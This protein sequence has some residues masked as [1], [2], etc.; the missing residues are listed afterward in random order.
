MGIWRCHAPAPELHQGFEMT[1]PG[2]AMVT[3]AADFLICGIGFFS[4]LQFC[5]SLRRQIRFSLP[6]PILLL[7]L[8]GWKRKREAKRGEQCDAGLEEKGLMH[9]QGRG[10]H[11]SHHRKSPERWPDSVPGTAL[12]WL[13][14]WMVHPLLLNVAHPLGGSHQRGEMSLLC[15]PRSCK[16]PGDCSSFYYEAFLE[17]HWVLKSSQR[18][19]FLWQ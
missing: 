10:P 4:V 1:F 15:R 6:S 14:P 9:P 18:R 5:N 12:Q 2:N 11:L 17:S 3:G 7:S 16:R 8:P 13:L 19:R